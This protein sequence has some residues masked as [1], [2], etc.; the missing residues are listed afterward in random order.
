[1]ID[2]DCDLNILLDPFF[3][4]HPRIHEERVWYPGLG[5]NA[6]PADPAD[7]VAALEMADQN[8]SWRNQFRNAYWDHPGSQ[9]P[10]LQDKFKP[11]SSS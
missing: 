7:L 11:A 6:D 9:V 1:M 3:L 5:H 10:R 2:G 8:D 4:H